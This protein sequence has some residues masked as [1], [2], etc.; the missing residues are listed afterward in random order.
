[1]WDRSINC[2]DSFTV[3]NYRATRHGNTAQTLM[4]NANSVKFFHCMLNTSLIVPRDAYSWKIAM[5]GW[6]CLMKS[7]DTD[8][9]M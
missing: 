4:S 6:K 3:G 1:M 7:W 2:N 5:T 9:R 8:P